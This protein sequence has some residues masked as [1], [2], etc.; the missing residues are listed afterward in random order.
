MAAVAGAGVEPATFRLLRA[1]GEDRLHALYVLA[2]V[3]G[4]RRGEL[5]GLRWDAIDLDREAL[6]AER[7]LQRVGGELW[8]VRPTTQASV[9][10]VL[11]PPLVVKAL[12]EHRERQAQERAA[13][14]VGCRG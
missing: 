14:G 8:L 12:P 10:T 6:T 1:S 9:R 3:L 4:V 11:L 13:A 2:L 7:A 5:L